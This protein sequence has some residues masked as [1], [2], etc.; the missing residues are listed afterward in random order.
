MISKLTEI[1]NFCFF[2]KQLKFLEQ[3]G[4]WNL[5]KFAIFWLKSFQISKWAFKTL[6][7]Q[8]AI[9]N[10]RPPTMLL[11][12][13][14]TL[15]LLELFFSLLSWR[16]KNQ[17]LFIWVSVGK[18]KFHFRASY[19]FFSIKSSSR[20]GNKKKQEKK[21]ISQKKA[22]FW[23]ILLNWKATSKKIFSFCKE[24]SRFGTLDFTF[25]CKKMKNFFFLFR[26]FDASFQT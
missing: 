14:K 13:S 4:I 5:T 23:N 18:E 2:V 19:F 21:L 6:H 15:S 22:S 7:V 16:R 20:K 10:H 9:P 11:F 17:K 26:F 8:Q 12:P 3:N 24:T 1:L 25:C